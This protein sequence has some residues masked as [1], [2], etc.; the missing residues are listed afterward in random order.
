MTQPTPPKPGRKPSGN[1]KVNRTFGF[2]PEIITFLATQ[3]N[4]AS[5]LE[6][7]IRSSEQFQAW[8]RSQIVSQLKSL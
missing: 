2:T 3:P 6:D 1:A 4:Q 8:K 7:T 5:Y